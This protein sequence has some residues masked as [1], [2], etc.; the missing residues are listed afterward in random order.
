MRRKYGLTGYMD[1]WRHRTMASHEVMGHIKGY[2]APSN[3]PAPCT[4]TTIFNAPRCISCPESENGSFWPA[5]SFQKAQNG[6]LERT[7]ILEAFLP[8]FTD[9]PRRQTPEVDIPLISVIEIFLIEKDL[10]HNPQE[11]FSDV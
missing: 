10:Q 1:H 5:T 4:E 7:R 6:D 2:L 8:V 11:E 3:T 9:L